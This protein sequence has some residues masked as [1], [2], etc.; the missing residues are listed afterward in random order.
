MPSPKTYNI[1]LIGIVVA[2][3]CLGVTYALATPPL[4]A[5]DEY[6]HYPFVQY[7]Q[8]EHRLPILDPN[9]PGLWLQEAAQPPL[10]YLLMAAL[11]AGINTSDLPEVHQLNAHAFIGDPKRTSDEIWV[12]RL[13]ARDTR[14]STSRLTPPSRLFTATR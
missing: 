8:T 13:C 14:S 9:E 10:Y 12:R 3:L 2:Y 4:E 11:T 5:S 7:V 1:A 6:K